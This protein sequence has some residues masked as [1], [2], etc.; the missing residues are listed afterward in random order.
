MSRKMKKHEWSTLPEDAELLGYNRNVG[1]F[2]SPSLQLVFV[3]QGDTIL[4]LPV[5][6]REGGPA[7]E[8]R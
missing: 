2:R 1:F 3:V 6:P 8:G 5:V 7:E 4:A